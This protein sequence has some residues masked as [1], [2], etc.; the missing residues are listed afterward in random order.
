MHQVDTV[1]IGAGV[2]GL[3]VARALALNSHE[4]I[5]L[6][7]EDSFGTQTS[8]RNSEVIHAGIYYPPGSLKAQLCR[9]GRTQL[10]DYAKSRNIE[11]NACGKLLVA[12]TEA[13]LPKLEA[14]AENARLSGVHDLISLSADEAHALEPE[15][16]CVSGYLSPSTGIIDVH[17]F[18]LALLGDFENAG[19]TL[20][21]G[22]PVV[23]WSIEANG[24]VLETGGA[25]PM[26]LRARRVINAAGHG[27]PR[28]LQSLS[29][30]VPPCPQYFAK[31]NYFSLTGRAPFK[32]LVYPMPEAAGLGVHATIDLSGRVRFGPDVE[33][34]AHDQ[35]LKVNPARAEVFAAAI[36]R[37]WP[38]L[39]DGALVPDYAGIRPKIHAPDQPMPDF[40]IEGPDHHGIS[41][42]INLLG[43]ESPG[44]T[45]ALALADHVAGMRFET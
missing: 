26:T 39:P 34:V 43:I 9:D 33:W 25:D 31:G 37:Y 35:D 23:N 16:T 41:G 18:M 2:I 4:T 14:I 7:A 36:R 21:C 32:R 6:E 40:R 42:L 15:V 13:E 38:G 24:F 27:A 22:T 45:S 19:G 1:V 30:Y 28:L 44:M 10:Y 29:T 17:G 8:S 12:T 11:F 5:I 3:A 20:V